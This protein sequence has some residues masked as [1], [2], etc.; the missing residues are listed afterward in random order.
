MNVLHTVLILSAAAALTACATTPEQK[1]A[2]AAAR[3]LYEQ[4]PANLPLPHNATRPPPDDAPAV[5]SRPTA[6]PANRQ[7]KR[8]PPEIRR[9]SRR[10]VFQACYKMAWQNYIAQQQLRE[11]RYYYDDWGFYVSVFTGRRFGGK[12]RAFFRK[13]V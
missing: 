7:T 13:A 5:Q 10:P 6:P 3:S 11:A 1:A 12:P 9:Q 2:R 4:K 8:V